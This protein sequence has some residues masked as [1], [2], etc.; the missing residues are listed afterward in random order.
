M[1][2]VFDYKVCEFCKKTKAKPK[3]VKI[4]YKGC[5]LSLYKRGNQCS[6]CF[7]K[8]KMGQIRAMEENGYFK[9]TKGNVTVDWKNC[10]LAFRENLSGDV[11][12]FHCVCDSGR[13]CD[14][15]E[16]V[17]LLQQLK[18]LSWRYYN[19]AVFVTRNNEQFSLSD[20]L[21]ADLYFTDRKEAENFIKAMNKCGKTGS[22]CVSY[23]AS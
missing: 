18:V 9:I 4:V 5:A 14:W 22:F 13:D 2:S 6:V 8:E 3:M 10:I 20:N 21:N 17:L 12:R 11:G 23:Y 7:R 1:A 16:I 15:C 19:G